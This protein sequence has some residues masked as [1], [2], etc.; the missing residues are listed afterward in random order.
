MTET[1]DVRGPNLDDQRTGTFD[2]H[3][4]GCREAGRKGGETWPLLEA[5][6]RAHVVRDIYPA[7]EF[8]SSFEM[9]REDV[10]FAPCLDDL[11]EGTDP[12]REGR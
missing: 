10:H 1:V 6:T 2:V 12:E 8:E 11:P 5:E 7:A 3:K 4:A 9:C